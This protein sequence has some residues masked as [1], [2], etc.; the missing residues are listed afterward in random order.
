MFH[1]TMN[2]TKER[3]QEFLDLLH[4]RDKS[5]D[6]PTLKPNERKVLEAIQI[7]LSESDRIEIF[8]KKAIYLY[9]RDKHKIIS[10]KQ[11]V[12]NLNKD[13]NPTISNL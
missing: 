6:V 4:Q 3:K 10:F 5:W 2:M 11:I 7:I 1:A 12:S 9:E 13:E 8:N